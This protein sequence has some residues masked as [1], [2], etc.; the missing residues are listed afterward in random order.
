MAVLNRNYVFRIL[1]LTCGVTS[2]FYFQQ[3]V[4]KPLV[5][6]GQIKFGGGG[7]NNNYNN[8]NNNNI[9]TITI[10]KRKK[11]G[12]EEKS[13]NLENL[14]KLIE[15]QG[16]RNDAGHS[17]IFAWESKKILYIDIAAFIS[18]GYGTKLPT[19]VKE[20]KRSNLGWGCSFPICH[21]T[22]NLD[23]SF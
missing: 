2:L 3:M 18:G 20:V 19:P 12:E 5:R 13:L 23:F 22:L 6:R 15:E 14:E 8:N 4:I 10:T 17:Q 21:S 7:G 9:P 16:R 11:D 1:F